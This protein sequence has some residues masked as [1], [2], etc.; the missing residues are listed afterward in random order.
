MAERTYQPSLE[1]SSTGRNK[2]MRHPPARAKM[3]LRMDRLT[4]EL[5][6]TQLEDLYC[7]ETSTERPPKRKRRLADCGWLR[8]VFLFFHL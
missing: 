6:V 2:N 4:P 1:H 8:F 5:A 3:P 7:T